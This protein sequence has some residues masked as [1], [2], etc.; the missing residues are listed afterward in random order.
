MV[1][2]I[3]DFKRAYALFLRGKG[4]YSFR[5]VG[6]NCGISKSSAHRIWHKG[7]TTEKSTKTSN[8]TAKRKPG[9][10][11]RLT[12]R[13]KCLLLRT[14]VRM[15]KTN[16][17]VTVM[18]LVKEAGLDLS[19]THRR[20]FT[21]YLNSMGFNFL[22]ARKKGLLSENDKVVWVKYARSIK[23]VLKGTQTFILT[24]LPFI[25]TECLLF[26]NIIQ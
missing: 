19:L 10:K 13:D 5:P 21:R 3:S 18:S 7:L 17:N 24:I 14:L 9:P 22:Q 2:K 4:K 8:G 15:R 12:R 20:T 11:A 16:C 23:S 6:A 25:W 1:E 26:T